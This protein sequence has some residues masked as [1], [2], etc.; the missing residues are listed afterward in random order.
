MEVSVVHEKRSMR[1]AFIVCLV[2]V[3]FFSFA[4]LAFGSASEGESKKWSIIDSSRVLNFAVLAIGLYL[5]LRKRVPKIMNSRIEGIKHQ[6]SE[7]EAKKQEAE[8]KLADYQTKLVGLDQES[9]KIIGEYVRQG[10]DAKIRIL[11]EAE[12]AADKLEEQARR[13]I[14]HE[15]KQART[16]LQAEV[17]EKALEKAEKII[18]EKISVDDQDRI[19]DEYLEKVV[20]Q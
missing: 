16:K 2:A 19:V 9:E 11:K 20:A 1:K 8:K 5:I 4:G 15:F 3:M 10:E 14:E 12:A 6:L 18:K 13:N 7:L 17:L